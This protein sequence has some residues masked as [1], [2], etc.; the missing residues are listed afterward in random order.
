MSEAK[1]LRENNDRDLVESCSKRR[2]VAESFTQLETRPRLLFERE[3]RG[4]RHYTVSLYITGWFRAGSVYKIS[5]Q[6]QSVCDA[7]LCRRPLHF[8]SKNSGYAAVTVKLQH[9]SVKTAVRQRKNSGY[10]A[11]TVKLRGSH[12]VSGIL[13]PRP[14]PAHRCGEQRNPFGARGQRCLGAVYNTMKENHNY[15][16]HTQA[17]L[18]AWLE[19]WAVRK[20]VAWLGRTC[21]MALL[22]PGVVRVPLT[23]TRDMH[24][25][26]V[27]ATRQQGAIVAAVAV[28]ATLAT[29]KARCA[30]MK[31]P[32]DRSQPPAE[33]ARD[34]HRQAA[35]WQ[36]SYE[37]RHA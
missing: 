36:T 20:T 15:T 32:H 9:F 35:Q 37:G 26:M 27:C 29:S 24:G 14:Q 31:S 10:A 22:A 21:S 8:F 23:E 1:L 17:W 12:A 33:G 5:A 30:R 7:Q 16:S 2:G 34:Q 3:Q 11:V 6:H 4:P 25:S 19:I 13:Q 18:G 28:T